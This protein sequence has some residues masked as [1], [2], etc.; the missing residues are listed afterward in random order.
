[1]L[2]LREARSINPEGARCVRQEKHSQT[3]GAAAATCVWLDSILTQ[4]LSPAQGVRLDSINPIKGKVA[5]FRAIQATTLVVELAGARSVDQATTLALELAGARSVDQA[6]TL[7]LE[8]AGAPSVDQ[9]PTLALE[10]AT[11]S[12]ARLAST[13]H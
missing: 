13:L 4:G 7:E 1:M 11:A 9:A 5:V 3:G 8:L 2:H 6:T 12:Y 10:L